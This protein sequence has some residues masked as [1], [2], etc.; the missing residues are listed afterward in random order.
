VFGEETPFNRRQF[1]REL[2]SLA[3]DAALWLRERR[4]MI[5]DD[6][7]WRIAPDWGANTFHAKPLPLV[8]DPEW[9]RDPRRVDVRSLLA[10]G[11]SPASYDE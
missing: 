6:F 10:R 11:A 4:E 5:S 3:E 2:W 7:D 9:T 8:V 1:G